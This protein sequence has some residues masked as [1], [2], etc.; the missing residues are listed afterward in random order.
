MRGSPFLAP[1]A[2]RLDEPA[3][4]A[5]GQRYAFDMDLGN[6]RGPTP[7]HGLLSRAEWE[8]IEVTADAGSAWATSRLEFYRHPLWMKQFPFA[9]AI[10]M[11]HRLKDGILEVHMRLRNL[12]AES[13]PVSIGFHPFLQLTGSKRHEWTLSIGA[14]RQWLLDEKKIPTGATSPIEQFFPDPSA[15]PLRTRTSTT[16]SGISSETSRAEP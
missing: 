4:Y 2:N 14:R 3:F 16:C 1:W 5:N 8:V 13:M 11:T 10:E 15:V 12:S 6:V 7:M 9:H